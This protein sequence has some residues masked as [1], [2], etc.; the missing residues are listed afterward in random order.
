MTTVQEH[1][2]SAW[3]TADSDTVTTNPG[4]KDTEDETKE[5]CLVATMTL[6]VE[7]KPLVLLHVNCRIM[8]NKILE[9][10]NSI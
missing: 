3:R 2:T 9:F 1:L 10:W 4:R 6:I 8:C 5:E 7:G